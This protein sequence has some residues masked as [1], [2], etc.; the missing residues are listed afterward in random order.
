MRLKMAED[1]ALEDLGEGGE[2]DDGAETPRR[3]RRGDREPFFPASW[4]GAF[5]QRGVEEREEEGN[6][7]VLDGWL[8]EED[9]RKSVG[10]VR[11]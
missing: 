1:D 11:C 6:E 5:Q 4:E 2:K 3:L 9:G 8:L 10:W 7:E